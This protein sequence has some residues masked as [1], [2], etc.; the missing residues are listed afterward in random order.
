MFAKSEYYLDVT[1][2][3]E[4]PGFAEVA[5]CVYD[6]VCRTDFAR[7]GFMLL[8][9]PAV[10]D[11]FQLRRF[12][13][14]LK[15]H[16]REIHQRKTGHSLVYMF[17][18]RFDQQETTKPHRDGG[19]DQSLLMLGY[20]PTTVCSRL[21]IADYTKCAHDRE[22]SPKQFL[23]DY[24]PMYAEGERMLTDY[25]T[26]L[27]GLDPT[28]YQVLVINNSNLLYRDDKTAW[29]GVLHQ[30]VIETPSEDGSRI[31]NSTMLES[32]DTDSAEVITTE[33]QQQFLTTHTISK[34]V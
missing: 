33:E 2:K 21:F 19:P 7:P 30:A 5:D 26:Q 34:R 11:S 18:G 29:L 15:Q 32:A 23:A 9:L 8:N 12:M 24:N 17:M 13:V 10:A 22:M 27:E 14:E 3:P 25:T 31:V 6:L 16:L 20:E 1:S 28:K 4:R